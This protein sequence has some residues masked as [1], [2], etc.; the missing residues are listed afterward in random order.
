MYNII[1]P[2]IMYNALR[3]YISKKDGLGDHL[4]LWLHV[5]GGGSPVMKGLCILDSLLNEKRNR[6]KGTRLDNERKRK[7]RMK[8]I[9]S[10]INGRGS[11]DGKKLR[12]SKIWMV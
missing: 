8:R 12:L 11:R 3:I 10:M 1:I 9:K 7:G 5:L 2:D 6:S 4:Y